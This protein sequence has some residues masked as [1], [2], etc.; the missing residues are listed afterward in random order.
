MQARPATPLSIDERILQAVLA[1]R[2]RPGTRLGE[3]QLADLFA[4]SRTLVR[5][6]MMR[7]A[8]RRIVCLATRRGW[9]VAEPSLE[10]ARATLAARSALECGMLDQAAP[11]D[12]A[13]IARLRAQI[14]DEQDIIEAGDAGSRSLALGNF[15]VCL[16]GILG[17][18]VVAELLRDLTA[19]TMLIATL[20]QSPRDAGLSSAEH[21]HILEALAGGRMRRAATLMRAHLSHVQTMLRPPVDVPSDPLA[22]LRQALVP[23]FP[24]RPAQALRIPDPVPG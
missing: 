19:R 2:I 9:F 12:A 7:L 11:P 17:N 10:E 21:L 22:P 18:P 3:Q 5:E 20:Y 6:A 14:A 24:A 1:G 4:V 15:H 13:G 8:A 16:A 23:E